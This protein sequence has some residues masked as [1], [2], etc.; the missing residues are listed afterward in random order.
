M[1]SQKS[2]D[3]Y[4]KSVETLAQSHWFEYSYNLTIEFYTLALQIDVNLISKVF[5]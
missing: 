5:E 1:N 4:W 3:Y 2:K